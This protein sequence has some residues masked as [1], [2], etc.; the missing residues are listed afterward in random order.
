[1]LREVNGVRLNVLDEGEGHPIVFLHGLGGCWRDWEPQL[2]SLS[3][4]FRCVVIEHRG[5][6][7]SELTRGDYSTRLFADDAAAVCA[8]LDIAHAH[9]VGLSMGGLIAQ[10]LAVRH[11]DLVDSLVLCDTGIGMKP[12]MSDWLRQAAEDTRAKGFRDS[13]GV[14]PESSPGWSAKTIAER[15]EVMRN[16]MRES[17]SADPDAWAR[18]AIAVTEHDLTGEIDAVT[19]P[20]LLIW[21]D[22][23]EVIPI[24]S[25]KG[26]QRVW[27]DADLVVLA[28]AGHVA[29]LE[30]PEAFDAAIVDFFAAHPCSRP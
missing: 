12:P 16:N 22:S 6:G 1:M 13:R 29:N 17:E 4:R 30:A 2:D 7:R 27:P 5:H 14:L 18:A 26:L 15:P 3:D 11:P 19:A 24:A 8:Q 9:V 25:A 21:G 23:D 28:D 10:A 20:V